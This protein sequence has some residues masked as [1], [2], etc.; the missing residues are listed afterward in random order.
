ML[1]SLF[2][3]L[4]IGYPF[5]TPLSFLLPTV[6]AKIARYPISQI[7]LELGMAMSSRCKR[8]SSTGTL[9]KIFFPLLTKMEKCTPTLSFQL[10][11][12]KKRAQRRHTWFLKSPTLEVVCIMPT[13]IPLERT[14]SFN[15]TN[16]KGGWDYSFNHTNCEGG[17]EMWLATSLAITLLWCKKRTDLENRSAITC[18]LSHIQWQR[19]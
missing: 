6:E 3:A 18:N 13:H 9:G 10:V 4:F 1:R 16:C 11:E 5:L 14:Y 15:H 17:W 7:V 8:K 12:G 19:S 2:Q